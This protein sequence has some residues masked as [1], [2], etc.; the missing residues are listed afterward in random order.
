MEESYVNGTILTDAQAQA[1]AISIAMGYH[2][3]FCE[4]DWNNGG[5]PLNANWE[6]VIY[7]VT[8][9]YDLFYLLLASQHPIYAYYSCTYVDENGVTVNSAHLVLIIGVDCST[10]TVYTINPWGIS[11]SQSFSDFLGGFLHE[12]TLSHEYQLGFVFSAK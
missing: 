4:S 1:Q 5:W 11:G 3:S 8:S 9:I 7:N 2:H 12:G 6:S 10:N